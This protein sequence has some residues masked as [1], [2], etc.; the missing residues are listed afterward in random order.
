VAGKTDSI[1]TGLR[2]AAKT[3]DIGKAA[4]VLASL[5]AFTQSKKA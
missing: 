4:E 5:V 3:I 1:S 2:L